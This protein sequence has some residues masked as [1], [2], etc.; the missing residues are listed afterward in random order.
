MRIQKMIVVV[1][2][3]ATISTVSTVS[4]VSAQTVGSPAFCRKAAS[5]YEKLTAQAAAH[6]CVVPPQAFG[7]QPNQSFYS[8]CRSRGVSWIT[9]WLADFQ[10]F[11][12]KCERPAYLPGH[13]GAPGVT[14]AG[15]PP[16][17][18]VVTKPVVNPPPRKYP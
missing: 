7:P 5:R 10:T 18:I 12:Q 17:P 9:G 6:G 2:L 3:F 13:G 15:P 1:T 8:Y 11:V 16:P 14:N 4:T